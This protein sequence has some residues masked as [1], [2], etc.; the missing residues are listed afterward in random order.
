MTDVMVEKAR[1]NAQ[2]LGY[3]NVNFRLGEIEDIPMAARQADV[4]VSNCVLNLV[5]NKAKAFEEI[6]RILKFG[7]HFSISDVVLKG[8]LPEG[9][10]EASEMYAGCVAGA[11]QMEEYLNLIHQSGFKNV[12][13]QKEREINIPDETLLS[14]V[15]PEEVRQYRASGKGIYSIT[16][17]AEKPQVDSCCGPNCCN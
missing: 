10:K 1:E 9:V 2:K 16:V 13:V 14:Y 7:G 8:T 6:F 12:Q 15:G 3:K 5:P 11:L 4:V 17:Y